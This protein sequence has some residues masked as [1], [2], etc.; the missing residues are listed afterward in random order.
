MK[1]PSGWETDRL[2]RRLNILQKNSKILVSTGVVGPKYFNVESDRVSN[3]SGHV[4]EGTGFQ[5]LRIRPDDM[6]ELN[7]SDCGEQ[8]PRFVAL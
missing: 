5:Q 8:N 7:Y 3:G 1:S 4:A 2:G 6:R